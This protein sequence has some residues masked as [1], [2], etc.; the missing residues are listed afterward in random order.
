MR[1]SLHPHYLS[2]HGSRSCT[3]HRHGHIHAHHDLLFFALMAFGQVTVA[4]LILIPHLLIFFLVLLEYII[5]RLP[6][7]FAYTHDPTTP[8]GL[9]HFHMAYT[10]APV[11]AR[12]G[13]S[14]REPAVVGEGRKGGQQGNER[15]HEQYTFLF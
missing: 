7:A 1:G 9:A 2:S 10:I 6:T 5:A 14:E 4:S 15:Y 8:N 11:Q 13:K 12:L 3:P